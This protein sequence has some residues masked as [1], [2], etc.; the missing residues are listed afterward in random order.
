MVNHRKNEHDFF[1]MSRCATASVMF[2]FSTSDWVKDT[3]KKVQLASS[4]SRHI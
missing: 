1:S 4:V 3:K 2:L